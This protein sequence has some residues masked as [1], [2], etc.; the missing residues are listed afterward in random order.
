[1]EN[2][3]GS[4]EPPKSKKKLWI[5]GGL[6]CFALILVV[7]VGGGALVWFTLGKPAL[8][9]MNENMALVDTSEVAEELLGS[10]ITRGAPAQQQDGTG[11]VTFSVPVSGPK[12]SGTLVFKGT[13][14]AD[15]WT[16]D[17]INL[18]VDGIEHD[19]SGAEEIFNLDIDD[20]Q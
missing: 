12:G 17:S 2:P 19:L 9:F 1:M 15:G 3:I 14:G 20:G 11:S 13:Y 16:R 10:P 8:D 7:C 18:N 4:V 6:G 5:F